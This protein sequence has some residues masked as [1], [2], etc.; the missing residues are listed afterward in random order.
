MKR[1]RCLSAPEFGQHFRYVRRLRGSG[2]DVGADRLKPG[3]VGYIVN[4]DEL[5]VRRCVRVV[6]RLGDGRHIIG[7]LHHH[8]GLLYINAVRCMKAGGGIRNR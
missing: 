3:L 2:G 1:E 8:T 7:Y 6:A 5:S 4:L